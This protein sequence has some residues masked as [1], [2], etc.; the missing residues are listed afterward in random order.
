[1]KLRI[2]QD[3]RAKYRWTLRARNGVKIGAS[4]QGY[5]RRADCEKNI[6]QVAEGLA[7]AGDGK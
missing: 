2:Y 3:K 7:I 4:S 5:R 1:M 6:R